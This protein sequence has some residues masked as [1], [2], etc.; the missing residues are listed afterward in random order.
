MDV[1][2]LP[3]ESQSLQHVGLQTFIFP[4]RGANCANTILES[5]T[6]V[7]RSQGHNISLFIVQTAPWKVRAPNLMVLNTERIHGEKSYT[8]S[9]KSW[10]FFPNLRAFYQGLKHT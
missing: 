3:K 10:I 6:A 7:G 8:S 4:V 9:E 5:S 2:L 1:R